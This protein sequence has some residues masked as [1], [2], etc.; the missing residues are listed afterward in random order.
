MATIETLGQNGRDS[1]D[2]LSC[3]DSMRKEAAGLAR[4]TRARQQMA[5]WTA[6]HELL[7]TLP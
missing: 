6:R 4:A 3:S 1:L 7:K 5:W 2:L